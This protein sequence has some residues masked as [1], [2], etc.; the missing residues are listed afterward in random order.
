M[1]QSSEHTRD[2]ERR[3]T[4]PVRYRTREQCYSPAETVRPSSHC[5]SRCEL[6][7]SLLRSNVEGERSGGPRVQA[8]IYRTP[9]PVRIV[10]RYI[11]GQSASFCFPLKLPLHTFSFLFYSLV[12]HAPRGSVDNNDPPSRERKSLVLLPFF[13]RAYFIPRASSFSRVI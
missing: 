11:Q 9:H 2:V 13:L 3:V 4:R 1:D 7:S 12:T 5:P 6:R 8:A 10:A